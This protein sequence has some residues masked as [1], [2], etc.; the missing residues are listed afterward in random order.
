VTGVTAFHL[1]AANYLIPRFVG[2][3]THLNAVSST[4][5]ILFFGWMWGGMGLLLAIPIAAVLRSALG[6]NPATA[7]L[8]RWLG[9]EDP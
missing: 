4:L 5:S 3:R 6:S 1:I 9:D 2:G 8:G 7:P